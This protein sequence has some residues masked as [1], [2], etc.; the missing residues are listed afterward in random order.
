MDEPYTVFSVQGDFQALAAALNYE[1]NPPLFFVLLHYWIKLFGIGVVSVRFLPMLFSSIAVVFI[2]LIGKKYYNSLVAV[3]ASLLYTFS[4]LNIMEAHDT[5]AYTLF[6]LLST[7]S[8]YLYLLIIDSNSKKHIV[9]LTV[10]NALMVYANIFSVFIIFIQGLYALLIP[11]VRKKI[12]KQYL[13]S[14]LVLFVLS[15]PYFVWKSDTLLAKS[16]GGTQ[17]PTSQLSTIHVPLWAFTNY[18]LNTIL[19]SVVVLMAFIL[20]AVIIRRRFSTSDMVIFGWFLIPY[21][22]MFAISYRVAITNPKYMIYISPAFYLTI[23]IAAAYLGEHINALCSRFFKKGLIVKYSKGAGILLAL[24]FAYKMIRSSNPGISNYSG[25]RQVIDIIEKYKSDSTNI[26][27]SPA[28]IG[29]TFAYYSAP[30]AFTADYYK[31]DQALAANRIYSIG[32]PSDIDTLTLSNV[33]EIFFLKGN[34]NGFDY[35]D[36]DNGIFNRMV[37]KAGQGTVIAQLPGY[38]IYRFNPPGNNVSLNI[39]PSSPVLKAN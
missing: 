15:L 3:I 9:T 33:S 24:L 22:L 23:S 25:A 16:G 19:L 2:Y 31:V 34:A 39:K 28:C 37:G 11:E 18:D 32:S 27:I 8:M 26:Y 30:E 38:T 17:F 29:L 10:V 5:R 13:I 36:P 6:V 35:Y 12:L 20:T 21:I 1:G 7:A 14:S 4:N